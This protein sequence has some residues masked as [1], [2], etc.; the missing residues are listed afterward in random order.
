MLI[1]FDFNLSN[2]NQINLF[3]QN[4]DQTLLIISNFL[5]SNWLLEL[6]I[7]K[8]LTRIFNAIIYY[9]MIN[10]YFMRS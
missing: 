1:W 9:H 8:I 6:V 5:A 4:L 2:L 3:N 7:L 10:F